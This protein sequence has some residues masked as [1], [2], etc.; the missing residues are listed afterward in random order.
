MKILAGI[1][2]LSLAV[3]FSYAQP[4]PAVPEECNDEIIMNVK[5]SWKKRSDANMIP[6]KNQSQINNRI[7]NIS[8]LFQQAYPDPRGAEAAW[9]RS[10]TPPILKGAPTAY[11]FYSQY[12]IWYCNT[13]LHKL[14]LGIETG[15]WAYVFVN[16]FSWFMSNQYDKMDFTVNGLTV[17]RLPAKKGTWKGYPLYEASSH[18]VR[19]CIV[20][21]RANQ[22]PW[23]PISQKQYLQALRVRWDDQRTQIQKSYYKQDSAY[24]RSVAHINKSMHMSG[25]DKERILADL[26]KSHDNNLK[27]RPAD[28]TKLVGFWNNKINIIDSYLSQ[29]DAST[30]QQPA[31]IKF[32]SE[33]DGSFST[34]DKRGIP[35]VTVNP[36]YFN[37]Q[38]PSY[39]PQMMVL[40]W[41]W[42]ES[43]PS[44]DFKKNFESNFPIEKLQSM[45]DQ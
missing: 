33:F 38:L 29:T 9:Y 8:K 18:N 43:A 40:Y 41:R 21:T 3:S 7:D 12:K 35:L 6:D 16:Y 2:L 26:Q 19:G 32:S 30:L 45:I 20:L 42:E 36:S 31:I 5:G 34:E 28:S 15:T 1:L 13:N 39:V 11:A 10:M 4:S 37:K 27:R 17:Y 25:A 22:L 23:K 44:K 14:L 24:Q